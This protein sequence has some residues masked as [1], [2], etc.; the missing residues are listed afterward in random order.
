MDNQNYNNYNQGQ[1]NTPAPGESS[2]KYTLWLVL[3][4]V[5]IVAGCCC[6]G[7]IFTL[8]TGILTIVFANNGNTAYKSGDMLT[9]DSKMKTAMIINIAGWVIAVIVFILALVTG[10]FQGIADAMN[11]YSY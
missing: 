4:I 1:Y 11:S 9:H 2:P 8:V 3:G 7:G 10:A 6:S 5:Q